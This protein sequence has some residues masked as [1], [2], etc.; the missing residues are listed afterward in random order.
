[1]GLIFSQDFEMKADS[2]NLFAAVAV[3]VGEVG[4]IVMVEEDEVA[5]DMADV[6]RKEV[7]CFVVA[8]SYEA[9]QRGRGNHYWVY[10]VV[11]VRSLVVFGGV[12]VSLW[13]PAAAGVSSADPST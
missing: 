10:L 8:Y 9:D 11:F 12:L 3:V 4:V 2:D 5:A 13:L 7:Y 1:M 6:A